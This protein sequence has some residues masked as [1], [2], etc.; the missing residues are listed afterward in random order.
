M[1]WAVH[2]IVTGFDD[3]SEHRAGFIPPWL[4]FKL[5]RTQRRTIDGA[6]RFLLAR[7]QTSQ[8]FL[9]PPFKTQPSVQRSS[10]CY[11]AAADT[12]RQLYC[13]LAKPGVGLIISR[14]CVSNEC[15]I[16]DREDHQEGTHEKED[17][18]KVQIKSAWLLRSESTSV[19]QPVAEAEGKRRANS[20]VENEADRHDQIKGVD[21]CLSQIV[22]CALLYIYQNGALVQSISA[23]A[24]C[25]R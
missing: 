17:E 7:G 11:V 15:G 13:I 2:L 8:A 9:Y 6:P 4:Q 16:L 12:E 23:N 22:L 1:T 5:V 18:Y 19:Y 20:R 25:A 24:M 3:A 14:T 10:T 21:L